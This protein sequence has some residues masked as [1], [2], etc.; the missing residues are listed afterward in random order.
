MPLQMAGNPAPFL[1][2]RSP[3]AVEFVKMSDC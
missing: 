1:R 2:F 3:K